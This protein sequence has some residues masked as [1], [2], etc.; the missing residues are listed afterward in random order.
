MELRKYNYI[1]SEGITLVTLVLT[2]IILLILS[3]LI[4]TLS[5]GDNGLLQRARRINREQ[6]VSEEKD[7]IISIYGGILAENKGKYDAS[8]LEKELKMTMNAKGSY[9]TRTEYLV[10][11]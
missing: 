2:I 1:K 6:I 8:L 3:A 9:K 7:K 11:I 5:L 4:I 10:K